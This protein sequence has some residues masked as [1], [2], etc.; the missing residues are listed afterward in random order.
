LYYRVYS[1][2]EIDGVQINLGF[3]QFQFDDWPVIPKKQNCP[4]TELSQVIELLELSDLPGVR[5]LPIL[6][7]CSEEVTEEWVGHENGWVGH[8][9]E[10]VGHGNEWVG[11]GNEQVCHENERVVYPLKWVGHRWPSRVCYIFYPFFWTGQ[12]LVYYKAFYSL[13]PV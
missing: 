7:S 3:T 5:I 11:H 8:G 2:I 13:V 9:N 1:L 4:D 10:W 6:T 12:L